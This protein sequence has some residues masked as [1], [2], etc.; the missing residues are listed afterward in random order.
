MGTFSSDGMR[1]SHRWSRRFFSGFQSCNCRR[2][3]PGS[4]RT[5]PCSP[6]P[7]ARYRRQK[8]LEDTEYFCTL[9]PTAWGFPFWGA[10]H[11]SYQQESVI[12]TQEP[13]H[14]HKQ[15]L[16]TSPNPRVPVCR[17]RAAMP[18]RTGPQEKPWH[19]KACKSW[20]Q[21]PSTPPTYW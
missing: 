5:M 17:I 11:S 9:L 4:A 13:Q 12:L 18:D 1:D 3:T 14:L 20:L 10:L 7:P 8:P 2:S 15:P 6:L 21:P 16:K 19:W